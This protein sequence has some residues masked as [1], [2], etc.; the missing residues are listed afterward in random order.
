SNSEE[1]MWVGWVIIEDFVNKVMGSRNEER[2]I[3]DVMLE[4]VEGRVV[5]VRR[6]SSMEWIVIGFVCGNGL[7]WGIGE[8]EG[9]RW[10]SNH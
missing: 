7:L 3:G 8:V 2:R 4:I 1:V 6:R 9:A 10:R 5:M